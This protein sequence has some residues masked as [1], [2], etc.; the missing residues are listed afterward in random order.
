MKIE[1]SVVT[2]LPGLDRECNL[3]HNFGDPQCSLE[4]RAQTSKAL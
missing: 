3:G 1:N 2:K 4:F